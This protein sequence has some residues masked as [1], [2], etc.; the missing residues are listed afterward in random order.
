MYSTL[1]KNTQGRDFI[2]GDLHGCYL[3]LVALLEHVDFNTETDR[4]FLVGDLVDRGPNSM[5]CLRL[6]KAP[7][8]YAVKGNHEDMFA[9]AISTNVN[10]RTGYDMRRMFIWNGGKWAFGEFWAQGEYAAGIDP[11][12][13]K[14]LAKVAQDLPHV[15]T[16]EDSFSVMHAEPPARKCDLFDYAEGNWF[17]SSCM[18][19]SVVLW[20]R[21]W[22][23]NFYDED[24]REVKHQAIPRSSLIE[25][26]YVGHTPVRKPMRLGFL[27]N[28]DTGAGKKGFLTLHCHTTNE[29]F[30]YVDGKVVTNNIYVYRNET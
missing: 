24:P 19:G 2:A 15:L 6:L 5:E 3:D 29:T 28:L 1:P 10:T 21:S 23:Y 22:F 11:Q 16:V 25:T 9:D 7:Y 20:G 12:E 27:V 4:L 17:L 18:D 14:A 13:L 30:S 26:M 8:V